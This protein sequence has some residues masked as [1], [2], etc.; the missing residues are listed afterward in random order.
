[1]SAKK[2]DEKDNKEKKKIIPEGTLIAQVDHIVFMPEKPV[3]FFNFLSNEL[4]L[5]VAWVYKDYGEFSCGGV[6]AGNIN[7]ESYYNPNDSVTTQSKTTG[8]AFEPAIKTDLLTKEL[9]KN[10]I[11]HF[12]LP[13]YEEMWTNTVLSDMLPGSQ[14][15]SCEYHFP[16]EAIEFQ[17]FEQKEKLE[18][19]NGGPLGI[20]HVSKITIEVNNLEQYLNK[21]NKI[22]YPI[23]SNRKNSFVFNDGV[24]IQLVESDRN[25]IRS[26]R[27]KVKSIDETRNYLASREMLG[28]N[29]KKVIATNP[30][31]CYGILFE[32]E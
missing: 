6:A 4:Q 29:S 31:K 13:E 20:E 5:P 22:L 3:E 17:R 23:K 15:F 24:K 10:G 18:N 27:F 21:W 30:N 25:C 16:K 7:L 9:S 11:N 14:I 26:I 28:E 12:V 32:F 19:V 8:I 1:M 2:G